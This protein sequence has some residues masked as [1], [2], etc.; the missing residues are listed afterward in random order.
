MRI[1]L[2]SFIEHSTNHV[3]EGFNIVHESKECVTWELPIIFHCSGKDCKN[4]SFAWSNSIQFQ[5]YFMYSLLGKFIFLLDHTGRENVRAA[6]G[7]TIETVLGGELS[8]ERTKKI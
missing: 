7:H 6:R 4:R 2:F 8:W 1:C 5:D 3:K